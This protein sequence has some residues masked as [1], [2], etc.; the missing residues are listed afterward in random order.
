MGKTSNTENKGEGD[1]RFDANALILMFSRISDLGT[2]Q[3][4]IRYV[5]ALADVE[6]SSSAVKISLE[7]E[8]RRRVN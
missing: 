5:R 1:Q 4:V 7:F 6:S 2:R 8:P 3:H